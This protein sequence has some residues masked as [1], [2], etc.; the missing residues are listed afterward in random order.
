MEKLLKSN[1]GLNQKIVKRV[2]TFFLFVA[3]PGEWTDIRGKQRHPN[4]V[5][6]PQNP[7]PMPP[8]SEKNFIKK[9]GKKLQEGGLGQNSQKIKQKQKRN[10]K[11]RK[12]SR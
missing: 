6:T 1:I 8:N 4:Y 3:K 10:K 11:H 9:K 5:G 12:N 7:H 2:S